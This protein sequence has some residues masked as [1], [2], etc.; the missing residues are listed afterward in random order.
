MSVFFISDL[1][2]KP[3]RPDLARA[4]SYFLSHTAKDADALY[5]LGD[6]FDAWIGDDAPVPGIEPLVAQLKALSESGCKIYFQHGNRDFLVGKAFTDMIGAEL[7]TEKVVHELSIG[8]ALILHGD[9]LCIDDTD[10]MQ[11][12]AMVRNPLW[13]QQMLSKSVAERIEM[14]RQMRAA[15]KEQTAAKDEYITDVNPAEVNTYLKDAD[16]AL[17]IH[18]H[19]HRPMV[20]SIDNDGQQATRIVL[21]DWEKLGWYLKVDQN[22][23]ELISF[24]IAETIA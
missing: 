15:S 24:P 21:G 11:F 6:I 20:H 12:R 2:L 8:N 5:L 19:T 23:Y 14:A 17:M 10:Y 7:L 1:H 3:E 18:G 16:V 13:Q 9:Q 4:F 22:D